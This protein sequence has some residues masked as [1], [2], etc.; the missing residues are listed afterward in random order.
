MCPPMMA[1][2][3]RL[4]NTI[5]L[6]LPSAHPSPQQ[7]VDRFS[8]FCTAHG[9]MMSSGMPGHVLSSNN[10][11]L[12]MWDLNRIYNTCFLGPTQVHNPNGISIG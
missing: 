4:A 9:R 1:H 7:R 3:H 10:C 12:R 6:V 11:P 2:W 5:E 8:H